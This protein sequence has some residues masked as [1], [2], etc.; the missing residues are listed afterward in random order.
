V[1][2]MLRGS[3]L[4]MAMSFGK[5]T[6]EIGGARARGGDADAREPRRT[7]VTLGG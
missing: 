6:D 3:W 2:I 1:P 4:V 5:T 7:R